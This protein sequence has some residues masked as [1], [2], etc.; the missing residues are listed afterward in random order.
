MAAT[1]GCG[2]AGG[3]GGMGSDLPPIKKF[4]HVRATT[5][6]VCLP[7]TL[8]AGS[9]RASPA[10]SVLWP[11]KSPVHTATRT[12]FPERCRIATFQA[13]SRL[14]EWGDVPLKAGL[15]ARFQGRPGDCSR[16]FFNRN[17]GMFFLPHRRDRDDSPPSAVRFSSLMAESPILACL[18]TFPTLP[19]R[20]SCNSAS[21]LFAVSPSL[22]RI[23]NTSQCLRRYS[24]VPAS[25]KMQKTLPESH[26][27]A[28]HSGSAIT[29]A[30]CRLPQEVDQPTDPS[31]DRCPVKSEPTY[32]LV[33]RP[34]SCLLF[35]LFR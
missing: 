34:H 2:G 17:K 26:R 33:C 15:L 31:A 14:K 1:W 10:G 3:C 9:M 23:W 7:A 21:A 8:P 12:N 28:R 30:T 22:A 27:R 29:G 11:P 5:A 6:S 16:S 24:C 4:R 13:Y 19:T 32:R 20:F 25:L 35:W 18:P